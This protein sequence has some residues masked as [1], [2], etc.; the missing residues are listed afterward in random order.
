MSF[1]GIVAIV[2]MGAYA[3]WHMIYKIAPAAAENDTAKVSVLGEIA[4][5]LGSKSKPE[6]IVKTNLASLAISEL[7][8]NKYRV[9]SRT[10]TVSVKYMIN[11]LQTLVDQ[12]IMLNAAPETF[13]GYNTS[14]IIT[15]GGVKH[16]LI[17]EGAMLDA[18]HY[19]SEKF[20]LSQF[21]ETSGQLNVG[22]ELKIVI[23]HEDC[24]ENCEITLYNS[25]KSAHLLAELIAAEQPVVGGSLKILELVQHPGALTP[26]F[27]SV[28]FGYHHADTTTLNLSFNTVTTPIGDAMYHVPTGELVDYYADQLL[29]GRNVLIIGKTGRGKTVLS[30][31][32]AARVLAAE[33]DTSII[34]LDYATINEITKP[35]GK[36]VLLSHINSKKGTKK[37]VLYVDEGQQITNSAQLTPLLE[38][39]EGLHIGEAQISVLGSVSAEK[40]EDLDPALVRPG[41][42][43]TLVVLELLKKKK[44]EA[45]LNH[46][47]MRTEW[48]K[49]E[50]IAANLLSKGEGSLAEVYAAFSPKTTSDKWK[51]TFQRWKVT[52]A[53]AIT[54]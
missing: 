51:D 13:G 49:N 43:N 39:M 30:S 53:P 27:V 52:T 16:L 4:T 32:V 20:D 46:L 45:L 8:T 10:G 48:V 38:F 44:M 54:S 17:F 7:G 33:P 28:P 24:D 19:R 47:S 36:A 5:A 23:P 6:I 35:T 3:T 21:L 11:T 26:S 15:H 14:V 9:L 37:I 22:H 29:Q 41:R 18:K 2:G 40:K 31:N 1:I 34:R 42:A 25:V 50:A 12:V